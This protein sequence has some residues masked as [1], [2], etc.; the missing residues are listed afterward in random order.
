VN[1]KE[2]AVDRDEV[3]R[4]LEDIRRDVRE[5]LGTKVPEVFDEAVREDPSFYFRPGIGIAIRSD[6]NLSVTDNLEGANENV[7]IFVPLPSKAPLVGPV[8]NLLRRLS[9]PVVKVFAG[10]FFSRQRQFNAHTVRHLNELGNRLETRVRHLETALEEWS[11]NPGGLDGRMRQALNEYD[12]AL[13]QRHMTLF[14]AL[15]EEVLVAHATAGALQQLEQLFVERAQAVDQ[16]FSEKD[17][18]LNSAGDAL[19]AELNEAR[20]QSRQQGRELREALERVESQIGETMAMRAMLRKALDSAAAPATGATTPTAAP[21]PAGEPGAW[22]ELCEW[23]G[24]EDYRSFQDRFRGDQEAITERMRAHVA[25]FADVPGK[26]ADL[27]CGRGEFLDL[28]RTADI[29]AFGVE[30]NA[31]DVEECKRRGHDA[32]VA[33]LFEW[34]EACPDASLG[35]IF[36]AQVIEHLPPM[37]WQRVVELATA[38]LAP[39]GRVVIETINPESLY[40]LARAYVI[41]PTHIRPV[42]PDLLAFLARRAGLH[43]VEVERHTPVPDEERPTGLGFFQG[44]P[45][46]DTDAELADLREAMLRLDRICCAPQEYTL[47][48]SRPGGGAAE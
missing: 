18:A 10:G 31:A 45:T 8:I 43:P 44:A 17:D 21:A 3:A 7:D 29:E 13:R 33:D 26:V 15:E 4:R 32:V 28:L 27:G 1:S 25:R 35:G 14:S 24:D 48:A 36:M 37:D 39:G 34:L 46:S 6:P 40:A 5:R 22:S 23:M 2:G 20:E 30:I 38:K 11:E 47:Q 19:N 9:Q 42:H 16:R 41:D 12:M